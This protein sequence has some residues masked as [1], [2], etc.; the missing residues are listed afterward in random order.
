M[1]NLILFGP[2]GAGK[3][4][5]AAKLAEAYDLMHISTGDILRKEIAE[6]TALGLKVKS[7]I[8]RGEL[9]SDE[10]LIEILHSVITKHKEVK[11]FIFDGFPRTIPQADA[12]D[13]MLSGDGQMI[14]AVISLE[15]RE[16]EL[17][18]RLLNRAI[19]LGRSDDTEE[20]IRK[21]QEVYAT[22]TKP[23]LDYYR[24]TGLLREVYGIGTIAQI[25]EKL[26][27]VVDPLKK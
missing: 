1:I 9:V 14:A 11:G 27:A 23:L 8:D 5:Q 15:V 26:C 17:I 7:I 21:R 10:I 3:G 13:R 4:T 16:E 2:P 24:K 19:E 25:F 18:R 6:Q 20:V 22:Q 12:L